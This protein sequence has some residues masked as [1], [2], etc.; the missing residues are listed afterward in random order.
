MHFLKRMELRKYGILASFFH[1]T[2]LGV[3][4]AWQ[5]RVPCLGASN[6]CTQFLLNDLS[7]IFML[8]SHAHVS[9]LIPSN[10]AF[11]MSSKQASRLCLCL[12]KKRWCGGPSDPLIRFTNYLMLS[13]QASKKVSMLCFC[14]WLTDNS[15]VLRTR[16]LA[17]QFLGL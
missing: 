11:I 17:S 5:F 9:N 6:W 1:K 14:L 10:F 8:E 4:P 13:K 2:S 16:C 7:C 15:V 3:P 12:S